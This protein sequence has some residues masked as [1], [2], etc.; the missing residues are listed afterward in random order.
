MELA[1]ILDLQ[2]LSF[3]DKHIRMAAFA[4]EVIKAAQQVPCGASVSTES[5]LASSNTLNQLLTTWHLVQ[6]QFLPKNHNKLSLFDRRVKVDYI[7]L[8]A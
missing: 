1:A 4:K 5:Y 8:Q 2:P 6:E 7:M 3:A